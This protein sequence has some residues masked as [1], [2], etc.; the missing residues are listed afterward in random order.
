MI[1]RM[2]ELNIPEL[3][4]EQVLYHYNLSGWL[5]DVEVAGSRLGTNTNKQ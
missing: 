2:L 3:S 5:D 4:P 1:C